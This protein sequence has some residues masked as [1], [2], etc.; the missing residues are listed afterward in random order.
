MLSALDPMPTW[1]LKDCIDV[2]LP[3]LTD[4]MNASLEQGIFPSLF[5]KSLVHPL[6]KKDNLDADV[7]ANY[8]PI[9]NLSF[10]LKTLERIVV[11]D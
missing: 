1:L 2:L 3:I 4:I 6:I 10:L 5:K 7:F 8:R 9:S 11:P